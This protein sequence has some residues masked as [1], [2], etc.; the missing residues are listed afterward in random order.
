MKKITRGLIVIPFL[1][2]L[3]VFS[4]RSLYQLHEVD[5]I[6]YI[7]HFAY[8]PEPVAQALPLEFPGIFSDFLMLK[9]LTFL[10]EK[11]MNRS[12]P[13]TEEW[14]NVYH[15]LKQI[16]NLDPRFL[17]PYIVAQTT[18]PF[19]AGM[20]EETNDLLK[21]AAHILTD[22][23]RPH[24]FLWHN[25]FY[26]LNNPQKAGEHLQKA[27]RMPGA[28]LY[29]STLAARMNLY[30]GKIHVAVIY[31]EETLRETTDPALRRFLSLRIEALKKIGYLENA[32]M[33]YRKRYNTFPEDLEELI[34]HGLIKTIPADPYGG[35]FYIME[36]GRVYS[37]SKLVLPK[38][39]SKTE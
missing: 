32:V 13:S 7:S 38:D 26:F 10:G 20:V 22:D 39:K 17:D 1:A 3:S 5:N 35:E 8:I 15:T 34:E 16:T 29:F 19:E 28:P 25:Y 31:L 30:A 9:T 4:V 21:K 14:Q 33:E 37:T 6:S 2:I 23:Y 12:Q 24:F 18:L 27:A 36:R 11:V